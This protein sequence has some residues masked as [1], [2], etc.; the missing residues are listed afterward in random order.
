MQN[1]LYGS[2]FYFTS[3]AGEQLAVS[4]SA[5]KKLPEIGEYISTANQ[6]AVVSQNE[7][8]AIR[9][10]SLAAFSLRRNSTVNYFNNCM[11]K[12]QMLEKIA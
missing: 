1:A 9:Y 12:A 8:D 5:R 7:N 4:N 10:N 2:S 3:R 11:K 6:E